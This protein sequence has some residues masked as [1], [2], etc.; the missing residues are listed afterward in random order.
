MQ[1]TREFVYTV[2]VE[3][4]ERGPIVALDRDIH[5]RKAGPHE[6]VRV[7]ETTDVA[8]AGPR[9]VQVFGLPVRADGARKANALYPVVIYG[10][11]VDEAAADLLDE[12]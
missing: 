9:R 5:G 12:E 4:G 1:R 2:E 6:V 7:V 10:V 8:Y 3:A 11:E